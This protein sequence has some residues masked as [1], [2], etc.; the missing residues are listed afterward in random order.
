MAI[1][2]RIE[3]S[4]ESVSPGRTVDTE[5]DLA[6]STTAPLADA[7]MIGWSLSAIAP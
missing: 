2:D 7:V 5:H 6:L 3:Y 1:L 4:V